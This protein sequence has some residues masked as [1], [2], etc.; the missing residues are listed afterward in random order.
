MKVLVADDDPCG[1]AVLASVLRLAGYTCVV[2]CDGQE[3]WSVL[4]AAN[5]PQVAFLDWMM[6][7]L[8]GVELCRRVRERGGSDY[9]YITIVSARNKQQDIVFGFQSGADDFITKPYKP[10]DILARLRVAERLLRSAAASSGLPRALAEARENPSGDVIARTLGR[11]GR[12]IYHRGRIAWAHVSDE[13]GTLTTIL[14]DEPGVSRDDVRAVIEECKASGQNFADVLVAWNLLSAARLRVI[15]R[16]WIRG[17]IATIAAFPLPVVL[18]SPEPRVTTGGILFDPPEVLPPELGPALL[19]RSLDAANGPL[20]PELPADCETDDL[21]FS[22]P[23]ERALAIEGTRSVA[24]FDLKSGR[25][26]GT[27]GTPLDTDLVWSQ[28]RLAAQGDL[29]DELED[30]LISTRRAS[31]IVRWYTRTPARLIFLTVDRSVTLGM[32]R[33][34]LLRCLPAGGARDVAHGTSP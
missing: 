17:K 2:A 22:A 6:P 28:L 10:E 3:A 1:R 33:H 9:T 7:G 30:L 4:Q 14:A 16:D 25:C 31:H 23:L 15:L 19:D 18:F 21:E 24:I 27:R 11:V 34:S 32:A 20:P 26:L 12:I 8:D 5:P 13:P 29:W